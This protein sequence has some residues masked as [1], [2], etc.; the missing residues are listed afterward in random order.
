MNRDDHKRIGHFKAYSRHLCAKDPMKEAI[1]RNLT[2]QAM[3]E[4]GECGIF[5]NRNSDPGPHVYER[6]L[7]REQLFQCEL[8]ALVTVLDADPALKNEMTS[9][10]NAL[11]RTAAEIWINA[12]RNLEPVEASLDVSYSESSDWDSRRLEYINAYSDKSGEE[13]GVSIED[14]DEAESEYIDGRNA[15]DHGRTLRLCLFPKILRVSQGVPIV[16]HQGIALFEG[17]LLCTQGEEEVTEDRIQVLELQKLKRK[18]NFAQGRARSESMARPPSRRASISVNAGPM[19]NSAAATIEFSCN[20][21]NHST[22]STTED[23]LIEVIGG[24]SGTLKIAATI[25]PTEE[26]EQSE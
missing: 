21:S 24:R 20:L 8:E 11:I 1:W 25:A 4:T 10:F 23:D 7:A 22:I 2:L 14:M 16:I 12:R 19:I 9:Q 5:D 13:N 3:K 18:K 15:E 26:H 6:D 17:G